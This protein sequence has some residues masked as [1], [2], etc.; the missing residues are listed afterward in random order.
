MLQIARSLSQR[1]SRC[2]C[3][4]LVA[5]AAC[6]GTRGGL[7]MLAR[8]A[9]GALA[10]LPNRAGLI[11]RIERGGP[12]SPAEEAPGG[13][14]DWESDQLQSACIGLVT[15]NRIR[16]L[17]PAVSPRW[18]GDPAYTLCTAQVSHASSSTK[19]S[20]HG[21]HAV[22]LYLLICAQTVVTSRF[23]RGT[24]LCAFSPSPA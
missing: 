9:V 23:S 17:S 4:R 20:R 18:A 6:R 24:P 11:F 3:G 1:S 14:P 8:A 16:H 21:A 13:Q 7:D 15:P 19:P 10:S 12:R 2:V 22:L 5:H